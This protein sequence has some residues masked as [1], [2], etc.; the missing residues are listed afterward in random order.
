MEA[1]LSRSAAVN[2]FDGEMQ[3]ARYV[4][5]FCIKGC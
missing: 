1:N 5:R 3:S 4:F 2:G